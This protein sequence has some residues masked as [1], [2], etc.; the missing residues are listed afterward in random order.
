MY[1]LDKTSIELTTNVGRLRDI[2]PD[3]LRPY[4]AVYIGDPFCELGVDN[5]IENED[6][7]LKAVEILKEC[8]KKVYLSTYVEPWTEK[9]SHISRMIEVGLDA[10]IEAVEIS[11]LGV[12]R[13]ISTEFKDINVHVSNYVNLFNSQSAKYLS[14]YNVK[15]ILPYPELSLQ[16]ID[17]IKEGGS[18]S[19]EIQIHGKIPLG[20]TELCTIR[21]ENSKSKTKCPG[22]CYDVFMLRSDGLGMRAGGRVPFGH[23][24]LC[25]INYLGELLNKGYRYF[26]IEAL[27]ESGKYRQSVGQIYRDHIDSMLE[28]TGK[29]LE[30]NPDGICNGF[31]FDKPGMEYL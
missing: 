29:F 2:N 28:S 10:G 8:G 15:R 7:L 23:K 18:V 4:D 9:L 12:L 17:K 20:Y 5:I 30:I 21:P 14:R 24:D 13:L 26:R 27:F 3:H 25:M 6:D 11:D 31:Y 1:V 19:I 16:E 22:T